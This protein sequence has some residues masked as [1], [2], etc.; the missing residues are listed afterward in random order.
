MQRTPTNTWNI[1]RAL[2]AGLFLRCPRCTQGRMFAGFRML[3]ACPRCGLVFERASGEVTGG[4]AINTVL[5]LVIIIIGALVGGLNPDVPLLPLLSG[6]GLF[7]LLFPI[8]FYR[9]S[10]GLWAG[11]LYLTGDNTETD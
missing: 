9:S 6:L 10:R 8:A 5:T 4:M 7:A 11:V 2:G 3:R 1:V